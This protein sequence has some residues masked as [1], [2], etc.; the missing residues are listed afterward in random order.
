MAEVP[1]DITPLR[2]SGDMADEPTAEQV[3][4][5]PAS[6][7]HSRALVD[8][9]QEGGSERVDG[10]KDE[11]KFGDE[12]EQHEPEELHDH[13]DD[14]DKDIMVETEEDTVIY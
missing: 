13:H 11:R 10:P 7:N 6:P 1:A 8:G 14:R 3:G 2:D 9:R 4:A 12:V 5:E